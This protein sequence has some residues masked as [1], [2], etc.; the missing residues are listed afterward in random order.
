METVT[1]SSTRIWYTC[2]IL[3][4]ILSRSAAE[5]FFLRPDFAQVA[6]N[7]ATGEQRFFN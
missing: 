2:K 6:G 5:V 3:Y 4:P 1:V 7:Y